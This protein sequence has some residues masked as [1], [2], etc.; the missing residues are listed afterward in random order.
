RA[1]IALQKMASEGHLGD[2]REELAPQSDDDSA[3]PELRRVAE[4]PQPFVAALSESTTPGLSP[5]R[6]LL[7]SN[8]T[9]PSAIR[10]A[11]SPWYCSGLPTGAA[12][13]FFLL[14]A[15]ER[16]G[17]A[18]AFSAGLGPADPQFAAR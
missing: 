17:I 14:N 2:V 3:P 18:K 9:T 11:V 6:T 5:T 8:P 10:A 16:I 15:L 12:G 13:L 1:R 4:S 7:E